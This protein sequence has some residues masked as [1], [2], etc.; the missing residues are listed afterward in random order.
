MPTAAS[1]ARSIELQSNVD[2]TPEQVTLDG[3][4]GSFGYAVTELDREDAHRVAIA[5]FTA[6][7]GDPEAGDVSVRIISPK[8]GGASWRGHAG[9]TVR[10]HVTR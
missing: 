5:I 6:F 1:L 2:V 4:D 7:G 8:A 3:L 9:F 10:V